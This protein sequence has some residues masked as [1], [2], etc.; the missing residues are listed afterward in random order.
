MAEMAPTAVAPAS[1]AILESDRAGVEEG[2]SATASSL[3][4]SPE[5]IT[6][7]TSEENAV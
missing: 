6:V 1:S 4:V 2:G 7:D 5:D 3:S